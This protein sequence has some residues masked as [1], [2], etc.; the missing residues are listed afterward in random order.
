MSLFQFIRFQL[1]FCYAWIFYHLSLNSV[2]RQCFKKICILDSRVENFN[3]S[4]FVFSLK[5]VCFIRFLKKLPWWRKQREKA[6]KPKVLRRAS[7]ASN[8]SSISTATE[9]RSDVMWMDRQKLSSNLKLHWNHSADRG[10]AWPLYILQ[11]CK[12]WGFLS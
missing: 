6:C 1:L 3:I 11:I 9:S 7:F 4:N 12:W 5:C 10:T 2:Y 8:R